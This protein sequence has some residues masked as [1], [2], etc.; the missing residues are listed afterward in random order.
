MHNNGWLMAELFLSTDFLIYVAALLGAGAVAGLLAGVFGIGGGAVLVPVLYEFYRILE[1]PE[2]IRLHVAVATS[3]GVIVPT[4]L[5]S[6]QGHYKKGAV[7]MALLKSWVP[8]VVVGVI[9]ASLVAAYISGQGLKA[10]FAVIAT[11]VAIKMLMGKTS[12]KLGEDIPPYPMR[13]VFGVLIGF[14]S[15]LMGIGGGVMVNTVMTLYNRAIHQAVATAS[16]V[17]VAISIPGVIGLIWAGWG[18]E[19]TPPL[20]IGFVNFLAVLIIIPVTIFMAPIGVNLAHRLEKR[21]L[22]IGFGVFL[23]IVAARFAYSVF[24]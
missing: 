8:A 4:S 6:F 23:L 22:E 3:L 14:F 1:V 11:L 21:K 15:T 2:S 20:S 5:R 12:W 18:A 24:H 16:G 9:L 13:G 17:G 10:I 19:G 7:D